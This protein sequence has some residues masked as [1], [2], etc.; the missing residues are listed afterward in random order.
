MCCFFVDERGC[1]VCFSIN[2]DR[3][4]ERERRQDKTCDGSLE[5]NQSS[6]IVRLG[7]VFRKADSGDKRTRGLSF[8]S[9]T[10]LILFEVYF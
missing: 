7:R 4:D 1:S 9:S 8:F 6:K 2:A 10:V 3:S 5:R